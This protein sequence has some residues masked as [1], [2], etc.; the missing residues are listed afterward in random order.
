MVKGYAPKGIRGL[1][2]RRSR[3]RSLAAAGCAPQ[4]CRPQIGGRG[5]SV[6]KSVNEIENV[7][8][9]S[10]AS[11]AACM[12]ILCETCSNARTRS[13]RR[14]T[15]PHGCSS[16][17]CFFAVAGDLRARGELGRPEFSYLLVPP[18]EGLVHNSCVEGS[19]TLQAG[20]AAQGPCGGCPKWDIWFESHMAPARGLQGA[21]GVEWGGLGWLH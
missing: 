15:P 16:N 12:S 8:G 14:C 18:S 13:R 5:S 21:G 9:Q 19:G 10:A 3:N 1:G 20:L 2:P 17:C 7:G 4:A 6:K 11:C